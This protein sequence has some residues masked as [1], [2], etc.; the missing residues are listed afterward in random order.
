MQV[1]YEY[2]EDYLFCN[3][4]RGRPGHKLSILMLHGVSAHKDTWL[5]MVNFLPKNLH[6]VCEDMPGHE[7]TTSSSLDDLFIDGQVPQQILPGLID[8]RISHKSF[9]RKLF[10]EIVSEK[11]KYSLHQNMDKIKVPTEIIWGKQDQVLDVS[12]AD[13]LAKFIANCQVELLENCG[14]SVMMEKPRK[15]DKIIDDY[16]ASVHNTE[17]NKK[18]N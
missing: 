8:V 14:H 7:G 18:L 17:N 6:L 10:L 12:G 15:T 4:F 3:F 9:Y 11:F 16:L 1:C 13:I 2:H 5:N